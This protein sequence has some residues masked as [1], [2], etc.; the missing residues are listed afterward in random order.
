MHVGKPLEGSGAAAGAMTHLRK[1]VHQL[2]PHQCHLSGSAK[3]LRRRFHLQFRLQCPE[4][5]RQRTALLSES[6][7][8]LFAQGRRLF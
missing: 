2:Q 6:G 5:F 1:C 3:L 7:G 4:L 8:N